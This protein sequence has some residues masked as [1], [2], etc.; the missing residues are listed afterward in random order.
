[1]PTFDSYVE[2]KVSV[3][4]AYQAERKG[5]RNRYGVPEEP[6]EPE[7]VEILAV[8]LQDGHDVT[9]LLDKRD[10]DSLEEE[11]FKDAAARSEPAE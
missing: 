3:E 8:T 5:S 7:E 11:A 1:M 9:Q 10:S 6:D 4:Y 2:F